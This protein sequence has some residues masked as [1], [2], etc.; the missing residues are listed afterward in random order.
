MSTEDTGTPTP[1]KVAQLAT[2]AA[3]LDP[4]SL[5]GVFGNVSEPRALIRLPRG[6]TQTVGVGDSVAGGTVEAIGMA[7]IIL[8]RHGTQQVLRMPQG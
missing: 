4:T 2:Q 6:Q 5:I 7:L 1:A 8:S 3:Q